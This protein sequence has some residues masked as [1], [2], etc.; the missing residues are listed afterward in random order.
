MSCDLSSLLI[1]Y[2]HDELSATE[3]RLVEAHVR[4]CSACAAQL[5]NEAAVV[6]AMTSLADALEEQP[7]LAPTTAPTRRRWWP[8]LVWPSV[9]GSAALVLVMCDQAAMRGP[10]D[11]LTGASD[12]P[13]VVASRVDDTRP[14]CEEP[15]WL[16]S[17]SLAEG[18]VCDEP[19]MTL[20]LASFPPDDDD[21]W[22]GAGRSDGDGEPG[23]CLPDDGGDLVCGPEDDPV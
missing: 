18:P 8:R 6:D 5:A 3:S 11:S 7:G 2:V 16:G 17:E 13:L 20:A 19:L 14:A 1:G 12:H 10:G 15:T 4:D 23:V 21:P 9:L 22:N